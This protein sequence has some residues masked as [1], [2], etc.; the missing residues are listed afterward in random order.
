MDLVK[1]DYPTLREVA[2]RIDDADI[3][4]LVEVA[5]EML[6]LMVQ[7]HGIG[8]AAPQIGLSKR[9]FVI[10]LQGTHKPWYFFN[11]EIIEF[12]TQT[13]ELPEGCLSLPGMFY[14]VQRPKKIIVQYQDETAKI[15]KC[16]FEGMMARCFQHELDH[17]DGI[18]F[19]DRINIAEKEEIDRVDAFLAE[20]FKIGRKPI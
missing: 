13:Q 10:Q 17:L 4:S 3:V 20:Q 11:P 15:R 1:S 7:Q 5:K 9:L 16:A 18:L 8:L 19:V 2:E 6:D 14:S 12:G